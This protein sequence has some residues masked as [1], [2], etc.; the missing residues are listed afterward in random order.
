MFLEATQLKKKQ[1]VS[2]CIDLK[3]R[4][5]EPGIEERREGKDS[6]EREKSSLLTHGVAC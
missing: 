5:R 4:E 2:S 6:A 3:Q 1:G